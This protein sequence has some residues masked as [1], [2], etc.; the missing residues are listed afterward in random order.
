MSKYYSG[1]ILRVYPGSLAE[2]LE[3]VPGDKIL[4][5]NGQGLR[6]I[7]DLSFAMADEEIDMLVEHADGEQEM[8]SFEKE[9][10]EELGVEFESAVFDGIRN[11]A[12]HC[13]FCFVDM[14]APNMRQSLS[15]KDDDYRLSF[16]YG[17]FVTMTNMGP[18]DFRRI[19]QFHLSPLF[20][21]VQCM[22]PE[23]RAQMLRCPGAAKIA[24]QLD[25]LEAAGADYHTQVVLCA[26]L[27]DG[28]E[29]ER[30]IREVVARRP[31]ALSLAIVPV[32]ITKYRTD[33]FPLHQF[34]AE[35][36]ARVIDEVEK[37]Q[38][39]IQ[40]EEGRTFIYLGDELYFLAGRPVPPT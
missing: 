30:T 33:P 32:G 4:E 31:H 15:I 37:W 35:G 22:N 39:K 34:D 28:A 5:I 36:A 21:S 3:L 20:V 7:I 6:D 29:L 26:G 10:D 40:E 19:K 13:Y 25:N 12:N 8:I 9:I 2:E 11:C 38:K 18:N 23:L 14:I 1:I 16:L 24:E 17:N 27:N